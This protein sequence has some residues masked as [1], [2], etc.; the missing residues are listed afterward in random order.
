MTNAVAR[1]WSGGGGE[2]T[3]FR[4]RGTPT[5]RTEQPWR[6][7]GA[8]KCSPVDVGA[9]GPSAGPLVGSRNKIGGSRGQVPRGAGGIYKTVTIR[10]KH[11]PISKWHQLHTKKTT[12]IKIWHFVV[13]IFRG[14]AGKIW[15]KKELLYVI[16]KVLV[17]L[18][19]PL[20]QIHFLHFLQQWMR[21]GVA[22]A[23]REHPW[24]MQK[25]C[26][27]IL[28]LFVQVLILHMDWS[29]FYHLG[30]V[31]GF[32]SARIQDSKLSLAIFHAPVF[33]INGR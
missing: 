25:A 28:V 13:S 11:S 14:I 31:R 3:A 20:W 16:F 33:K 23:R 5:W 10:T 24:F 15:K 27:L 17:A 19:L 7:F 9:H 18:K 2:P 6:H 21:K 22:S 4:R 1:F 12:K 30:M 26:S 29:P 8:A 32:A